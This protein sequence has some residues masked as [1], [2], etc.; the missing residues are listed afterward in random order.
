[1]S[2]VPAEIVGIGSTQQK[3]RV[4]PGF[5]P[6]KAAVGPQ[7]YFVLSRIDGLQTLRDVLL[8]TGLPV[9]R[10][11]SIVQRLR[12]IGALLIPGETAAPASAAPS[13]A[14]A[15]AEPRRPIP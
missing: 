11:I 3:L 5:D 1:M 4:S 2:A 9:E 6:L 13:P 10:A 15:P 8:T 7:E 12:A 14:A